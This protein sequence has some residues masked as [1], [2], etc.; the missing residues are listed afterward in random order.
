MAAPI[1]HLPAALHAP[2]SV[3]LGTHPPGC[4]S[5]HRPGHTHTYT[6]THTVWALVEA[7][8]A[9]DALGQPRVTMRLDMMI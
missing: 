3:G 1:A 4:F 6:V 9:S 7:I 2:G 8:D 5:H